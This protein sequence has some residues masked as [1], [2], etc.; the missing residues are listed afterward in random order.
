M[1]ARTLTGAETFLRT[2]G[3]MGVEWIFASPGS[4]WAPVWEHLAKAY[5]PGEIPKYLSTR[6][7]EICL[8]MAS[9]Y[10]KTTGKAAAV[11]IHTTV[12][13]L[14]GAMAMRGA[15]HENV[16][17]M[18]FAGE[19]IAFGEDES[20]DP[21]A[22][23]MGSLVDI[24]GP[25][26]LLAPC[27]KWSFGL[28][29]PAV[30][31]STIQRA[32]QIAMMPPRGPSFVSLPI[33]H[34][35]GVMQNNAPSA[36]ALPL[37]AVANQQGLEQLADMLASAKNP[38]IVT[39]KAGETAGA[40]KLL[41]QIAELLASPV[42]EARNTKVVN[43]PRTH[44]LHAGTNLQAVCKDADVLFMPGVLAPWNPPSKIPALRA[45]TAVLDENPLRVEKPVWGFQ[46]DLTLVGDIESSLAVL[47]AELKKRVQPGDGT[48]KAR[49]E[50][51]A[52]KTQAAR[53]KIME[54]AAAL[55]SKTPIDA[56]WLAHEMNA[57][58]PKDTI[59]V[60]E[61][62]TTR[63][64]IVPVYQNCETFVTG[65]IGG[66]GTGLGTAIGCKAAHPNRPVIFTVGDGSLN[67]NPVTAGL[68]AMQEHKL[69]VL[70]IICNN[71]GYQ[72]QQAEIPHFYPGGHAVKSGNYSGTGIN[73][74]PEYAAMAPIFDGH[75]EK[76]EKPE[77][78]RPALERGLKAIASGK[79][80][81][82]DV[83]L[84][85]INP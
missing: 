42:V 34:L 61:T 53:R 79:L 9:G 58:L 18:I 6:H 12:G 84:P 48:R 65:S 57:V 8:G 50:S 68:G 15:L 1:D 23:W 21:G 51:W 77:D 81:V 56:A 16:P 63:S 85:P 60:D 76:V 47:L 66:L 7:E 10:Y 22:Q 5:G 46:C 37:R 2:L 14:H 59:W 71:R 17:M 73:P 30:L 43:F 25:A 28:N 78:V 27:V 19:S 49:A 35:M 80:A 41:V 11:M 40:Q 32:C 45:K 13:S 54:D 72:S 24:G 70:T 74:N 62:I 75:G 44:P 55:K 26:R 36:A 39:E 67:Y 31:P 83:R 38:V 69:P 33:E 82:I 20:P 64:Q 29:T 3:S 52:A 4:E